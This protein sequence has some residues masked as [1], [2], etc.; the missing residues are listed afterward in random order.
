M[1]SFPLPG[2]ETDK[3]SKTGS[4]TSYPVVGCSF[5]K[6]DTA[7]RRLLYRT[8]KRC[9]WCAPPLH[10]PNSYLCFFHGDGYRGNPGRCT[11]V[12]AESPHNVHAGRC[13][14][15]DSDMSCTNQDDRW[16]Y[17]GLPRILASC[18]TRDGEVGV[19]CPAPALREDIY[20]LDCR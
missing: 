5:I 12:L 9:P 4:G 7:P 20:K 13:R 14:C 15:A 6:I 18:S 10:L 11:G 1:N 8:L 16:H 19:S 3:R 2:A 17:F